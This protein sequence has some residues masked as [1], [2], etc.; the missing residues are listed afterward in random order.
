MITG[1]EK[2]RSQGAQTAVIKLQGNISSESGPIFFILWKFLSPGK[3][4]PVYKSEIKSLER[5]K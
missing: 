1:E 5:G 3:Y 4:K 2:K